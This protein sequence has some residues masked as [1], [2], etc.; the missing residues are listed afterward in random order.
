MRPRNPKTNEDR[1][2]R[3][4]SNPNE[5]MKRRLSQVLSILLSSILLSFVSLVSS[6]QQGAGGSP[7]TSDSPDTH[8]GSSGEPRIQKLSD[9]RFLID[10]IVVDKQKGS[11]SAPGA[12]NMDAGLIE[13]LACGP[14]GKLH[15][16]VLRLDVNP[17]YL[18][19]ALLL[20]GLEPGD[21]PLDFQGAGGVP[22]GD[23]VEIYVSWQDGDKKKRECR[24]EELVLN[25]STKKPMR[26]THWVFTGSRIVDGTFMAMIEQSIVAT[27][28]DPY[29]I[30]DHPLPTGSDDTLY[31]ANEKTVPPKGTPVVG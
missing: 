13:Y 31:F 21:A 5:N 9:G 20:L 30:I 6:A 26:R 14:G 17:A 11:V 1:F 8:G 3:P 24:A 12:V 19:I 28:H 4:G 18:Q 27:F 25:A 7:D 23:P 2:Y 10:N 16:S 15:E 29:A 22:Q